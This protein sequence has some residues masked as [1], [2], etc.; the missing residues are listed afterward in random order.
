MNHQ[1]SWTFSRGF[2][3]PVPWSSRSNLLYWI[4]SQLSSRARV[5]P[6]T[7]S[8]DAGNATRKHLSA[9]D[10][11][12]W[13]HVKLESGSKLQNVQSKIRVISFPYHIVA[14]ILPSL[15]LQVSSTLSGPSFTFGH[16]TKVTMSL[17]APFPTS[18]WPSCW[19][20]AGHRLRLRCPLGHLL[21]HRPARG[22]ITWTSPRGQDLSLGVSPLPSFQLIP[23]KN[24]ITIM[25]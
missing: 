13:Q 4:G 8:L 16:V 9:S 22:F 21:W 17:Y 10:Q 1:P 20:N 23:S 18:I 5:E 6:G 14:A 25:W 3:K 15:P 12:L 19:G 11:P 7:S 24:G 2:L